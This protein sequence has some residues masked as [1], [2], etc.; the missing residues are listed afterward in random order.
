ML[1]KASPVLSSVEARPPAFCSILPSRSCCCCSDSATCAPG[2]A[3]WRRR[4]AGV[5][6]RRSQ[7]S[8][9]AAT[10]P[11]THC[12]CAVHLLTL[13]H[14]PTPHAA[15]PNH[16]IHTQG[17]AHLD[18][19]ALLAHG[20][21]RHDARRLA[22]H[23]R[24]PLPGLGE[25]AALHGVG[26]GAQRVVHAVAVRRRLLAPAGAERAAGWLGTRPTTGLLVPGLSRWQGS[27]GRGEPPGCSGG[28]P[29]QLARLQAHDAHQQRGAGHA[30]L[31]RQH[32][33]AAGQALGELAAVQRHLER[34]LRGQVQGHRSRVTRQVRFPRGRLGTRWPC[35]T[36][37]PCRRLAHSGPDFSTP[38]TAP[39][40]PP[41]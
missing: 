25:H 26:L 21:A 20:P 9:T 27:M 2:G 35:A 33:G 37:T 16:R 38:A 3:G 32:L 5:W 15:G 8:C 10:R 41:G 31:G 29:D 6:G 40:P 17:R 14:T 4:D 30:A 23:Q 13:A 18:N 34:A 39:S 28:P 22:H 12:C 19:V 1:K 11:A 24:P 36:C 7:Q